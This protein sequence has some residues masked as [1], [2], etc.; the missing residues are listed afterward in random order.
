MSDRS[1]V[2]IRS[3]SSLCRFRGEPTR[4][5]W[6]LYYETQWSSLG[7]ESSKRLTKPLFPIVSKRKPKQESSISFTKESFLRGGGLHSVFLS[8]TVR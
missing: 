3:L 5:E 2:V 7:G 4:R 8:L 1:V 6:G